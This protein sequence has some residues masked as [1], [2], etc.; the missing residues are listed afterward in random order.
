MLLNQEIQSEHYYGKN[1]Y[2]QIIRI[3]DDN[4]KLSLIQILNSQN[5]ICKV[6]FY[7][8]NTRLSN[9]SI[10]N[11]RNGK[12]IKN[13]TFKKDGKS[14]SSIRQYDIKTGRLLNVSFYK[15]DKNELSSIIEYDEF[16][17][18]RFTLYAD[19]GEIITQEF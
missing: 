17:Q 5:R 10:Y 19:D 13:I 6:L 12:E 1:G 15:K 14:V 18:S 7:D 9:M 16:G 4:K 3:Y 11:P 2:Y 8:E